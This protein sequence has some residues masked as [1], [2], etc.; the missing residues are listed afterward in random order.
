MD[1]AEAQDHQ[2]GHHLEPVVLFPD[3][4]LPLDDAENVHMDDAEDN[5]SLSEE[6]EEEQEEDTLSSGPLI[7]HLC[8]NNQAP[9][10]QQYALFVNS[11][12]HAVVLVAQHPRT[13]LDQLP[14]PMELARRVD[15]SIDLMSF[16]S[17]AVVNNG[18]GY[19]YGITLTHDDASGAELPREEWMEWGCPWNNPHVL[20][21]GLHHQQVDLQINYVANEEGVFR[22][23]ELVVDNVDVGW[24]PEI[25]QQVRHFCES[26]EG[27]DGEVSEED[28]F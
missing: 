24:D 7:F 18:L 1:D 17:F 15:P 11:F 27:F 5:L 19:T 28:D 21:F 10:G 14:W 2:Q 23:C 4:P 9:E 13:P 22:I 6:E 16:N 12:N 20:L 25:Y 3:T 8:N 26:A